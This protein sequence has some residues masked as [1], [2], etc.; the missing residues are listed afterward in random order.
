MTREL[1]FRAWVEWTETPR[2]EYSERHYPDTFWGNY[3]EGNNVEQYTGLKDKNSKEIYEGDLVTIKP[4]TKPFRV[5]FDKQYASFA[6]YN[7]TTRRLFN[8]L[9]SSDYEVIGNIHENPELLE[10][11]ACQS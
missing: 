4:Y 11:A 9:Y 5:V 6:G 10:E 1:K 2:F 3:D 7:D 8:S